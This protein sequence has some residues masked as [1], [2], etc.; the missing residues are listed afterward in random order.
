MGSQGQLTVCLTVQ[1]REQDRQD[2]TVVWGTF[3]QIF[4][5]S[6]RVLGQYEL[7]VWLMLVGA[8]WVLRGM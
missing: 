8:A 2:R 3:V 1:L 4:V 6:E 5:T 7:R